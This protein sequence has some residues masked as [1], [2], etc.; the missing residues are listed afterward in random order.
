VLNDDVLI[1]NIETNILKNI[2][3]NEA[4][5]EL[6][7]LE[8]QRALSSR[9]ALAKLL[10]LREKEAVKY[11]VVPVGGSEAN[12]MIGE[13]VTP[14]DTGSGATYIR[15]VSRALTTLATRAFDYAVIVNR[16]ESIIIPA[17][18][19]SRQMP[20]GEVMIP[21]SSLDGSAKAKLKD[22]Y[23]EIF[24]DVVSADTAAAGELDESEEDPDEEAQGILK[25]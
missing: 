24:K 16:N 2:A 20:D 11:F 22:N 4:R 12:Y 23:L 9:Q 5:P 10:T 7:R 3:D 1:D 19:T 18:A 17:E 13:M 15:T 25:Y 8:I 14:E 21:D 6:S